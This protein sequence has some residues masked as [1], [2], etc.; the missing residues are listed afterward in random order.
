M[1]VCRLCGKRFNKM[2]AKTEYEQVIYGGE[3]DMSSDL[4]AVCAVNEREDQMD[5]EYRELYGEEAFEDTGGWT[6][7]HRYHGY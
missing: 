5:E 4:C 3:Y 7:G 2:E 6:G 1:A